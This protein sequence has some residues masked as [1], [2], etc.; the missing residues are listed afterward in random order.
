[1]YKFIKKHLAFEFKFRSNFH[2]KK[3]IVD[4]N[5]L[6]DFEKSFEY[7]SNYGWTWNKNWKIPK[8]L[9][10]MEVKYGIQAKSHD[11]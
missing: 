2:I 5:L 10:R 4:L 9:I 11:N 6:I 7:D 1:M 3:Q 8:M